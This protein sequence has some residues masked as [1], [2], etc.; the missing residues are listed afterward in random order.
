M[1]VAFD[2]LRR[3]KDFATDGI[4]ENVRV[5][6]FP[7][8]PSFPK[9]ENAAVV[10]DSRADIAALQ[11]NNPDPPAATEKMIR[12]PF[13]RGATTV[14]VIGKTFSPFVAVPLLYAAEPRPH[15]IDRVVGV[16]AKKSEFPREHG[17]AARCIDNPAATGRAFAPSTAAVTRWPLPS[18]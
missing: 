14:R 18:C 17:R 15:S 3:A 4:A 1:H 10:N 5:Q 11:R 9:F 8:S 2:Q 7:Q 12:G 16:G 6:P 13:T